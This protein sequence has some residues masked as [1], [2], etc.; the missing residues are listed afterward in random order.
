[1]E[2]GIRYFILSLS[3]L[4]HSAVRPYLLTALAVSVLL[5]GL[6]AWTTNLFSQWFSSLLTAWIPWE[7]SGEGTIYHWFIQILTFLILLGIYK[8]IALGVLAPVMSLLSEKIEKVI[9]PEKQGKNSSG[10]IKGTIRGLRVNFVNLGKEFMYTIL[11]LLLS[12][13]PGVA[14]ITTP[15][16]FAV[17]CY[18]AGYGVMDFYL[19]RYAGFSASNRI[20]KK[21]KWF[22][23]STGAFFVVLFYIPFLGLILAPILG[24]IS[25]TLYMEKEKIAEKYLDG[26]M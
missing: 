16:I 21:E 13:I 17:Q 26:T 10:L 3:W 18:Y 24:T 9:S 15:L 19:E 23:V 2:K 5:F 22:A 12:L 4:F 8:Y 25:S 11:L 14:L 6:L 20:V 1:M 7:W